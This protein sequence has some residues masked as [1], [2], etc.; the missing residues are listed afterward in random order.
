MG[1]RGLRTVCVFC[2]TQ[3]TIFCASSTYRRDFWLA[4]WESSSR[5]W[6]R[7]CAFRRGRPCTTSPGG[8]WWTR[9]TRPRAASSPPPRDSPF[10]FSMPLM[11]SYAPPTELWSVSN[12]PRVLSVLIRPRS[13]SID[14]PEKKKTN[15]SR[16]FTK[17]RKFHVM[18]FNRKIRPMWKISLAFVVVV[19]DK[20]CR[21]QYFCR[22]I[23]WCVNFFI[24]VFF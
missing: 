7:F 6:K 23:D 24:D 5:R 21:I 1:V 13:L 22:L 17:F 20:H 9:W 19:F 2:P 8:Q 4:G 16:K 12:V 15:L 11:E 18:S 3:T 10:T 14:W